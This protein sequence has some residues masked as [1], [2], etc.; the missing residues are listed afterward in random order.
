[1]STIEE[2][3]Q[4]ARRYFEALNSGDL[5]RY[6]SVLSEELEYWVP[7]NWQMA[8]KHTKADLRRMMIEFAGAGMLEEPIQLT[9][10]IMTAEGDR[11]AVEA[12]ST[13]KMKG[14]K[15][16]NTYHFLMVIKEGKVAKLHEYLDTKTAIDFFFP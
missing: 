15:Y 8:G 5:E 3:K 1:M 6:M 7:G 2:N 14:R 16:A 10:G 9:P 11:V 12:T 13:A 4:V